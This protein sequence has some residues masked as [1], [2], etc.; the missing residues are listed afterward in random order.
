VPALVFNRSEQSAGGSEG[1]APAPAAGA[2]SVAERVYRFKQE[3]NASHINLHGLKRLAIHGIPDK[4]N[5]RAV[6]WKV[7][8]AL[9]VPAVSL[10]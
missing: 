6:V 7:S 4:D 9:A 3:L 2:S 1:P 10:P 5:L 8:L